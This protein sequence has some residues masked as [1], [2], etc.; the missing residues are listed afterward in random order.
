MRRRRR[1]IGDLDQD[2]HEH[3]EMETQ[4]N[5]ER[6]MSPEEARYAALRKFGNVMRVKEETVEVWGVV[7]LEQFLRDI[8]YGLRMF[9]KSPGFTTVAIVTLALG[10]GANTAIFSVVHGVVLS[11][12]PYHQADQLAIVWQKNPLGRNISPSYP[13][14]EDWQRSTRSFQ[15]M[16]AFTWHAFDL[17]NPGSPEHLD[18]WQISSGFFRTLGA[19]LILG[20]DFSPQENQ[21]GGPPVAIISARVWKDRFAGSAAVLGKLLTM[22]GV[23]YTIVG[24]APSGINFS[25]AIDVYTPVKQGD[26]LTVNDRR[27]HA[28]IA[29]GRLKPGIAVAQAEADTAAVEKTLGELTP[30]LIRACRQGWFH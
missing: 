21:P 18:G 22:D 17:T 24:V 14:F 9:R 4:D 8:R 23:D 7:W 1:M 16:A 2:I 15:G 29:L 10:I 25:G 5:I 28:F 27:T 26:A 6:G 30:N 13:D 20:R 11:P 12:L 19:D 3:I